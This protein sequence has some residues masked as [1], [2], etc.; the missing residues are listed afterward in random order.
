MCNN[1]Y[2]LDNKTSVE[3]M[4]KLYGVAPQDGYLEIE[5]EDYRLVTVSEYQY[6]AAFYRTLFKESGAHVYAEGGEVVCVA[7]DLVMYHC[8]ET[9][10][11]TLHLKCGDV[12]VDNEKY[13]TKVYDNLTG[14]RLL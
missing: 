11:T 12:A 10:T 8:K 3:N 13:V 1:G 2:I 9:P 5:R 6:D 4:T 7:N 14:K